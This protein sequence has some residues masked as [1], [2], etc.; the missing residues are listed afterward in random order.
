MSG[1]PEREYF[2]DGLVEI[3]ALSN[4][5]RLNRASQIFDGWRFPELG[6]ASPDTVLGIF[7][8]H[9]DCAVFPDSQL[10][11]RECLHRSYVMRCA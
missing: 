9:F 11:T 8:G 6:A 2:A 3:T 7:C 1:D 5:G 4:V 10:L